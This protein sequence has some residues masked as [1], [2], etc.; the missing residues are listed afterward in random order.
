MDFEAVSDAQGI[1]PGMQV[2]AD[3]S[4][5][6]YYDLLLQGGTRSMNPLKFHPLDQ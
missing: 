2:A 4:S 6:K 1:H 5:L 3:F